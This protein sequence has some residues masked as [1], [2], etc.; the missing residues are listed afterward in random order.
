MTA[1]A[2]VTCRCSSPGPGSI[3]VEV[4]FPGLLNHLEQLFE[5]RHLVFAGQ[6]APLP[7]ACWRSVIA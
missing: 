7:H 3:L 1:H 4:P 2:A 6:D 5:R